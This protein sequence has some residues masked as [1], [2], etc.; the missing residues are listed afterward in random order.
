MARCIDYDPCEECRENDD[1]FYQDEDGDWMM[2]C[3]E[4]QK[5]VRINVLLLMPKRY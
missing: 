1:D 4:K 2:R 5:K 3:Y